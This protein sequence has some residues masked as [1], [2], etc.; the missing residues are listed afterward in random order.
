MVFISV[1]MLQRTT[2]LG[3]LIMMLDQMKNELSRFFLTFGLVIIVFLLLGRMLS[4]EF[5]FTP[6]SF[7]EAFLDL[8]NAFNG[9]IDFTL[10]TTP[11]GQ[12][13]IVIF[14]YMFKILL[15]SLLAA[16]FI[17]RYKTVW[18]NLDAYRRF[19]IIKLKNSISYDKFIG[20][21]TLTFFPINIIM[22]PFSL[23]LTALRSKRGSD[24]MLKIQYSFMMIIYCLISALMFVPTCPLLIFKIYT[25]SFFIFFTN[26]REAYKGE[27]LVQLLMALILGPI[28]IV[29]SIIIDLL[30][31]PN[32]LLKDGRNFEHKY[33]LSAD[34]LTDV[35]IKVV[36]DTFI[37]IFYGQEWP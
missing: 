13:Y 1:I 3:E 18:V 23:I 19:T 4:T 27:N 22:L 30:S 26:K 17:N 15:M 25:N 35:Q 6:A 34:R 21:V 32:V 36:M 31:L 9:N 8:F 11:I 20:G 10:W 12:I 28:L 16:M 33:Q 14:M 2:Y 7:F 5:K 37:K 24:I 29:L